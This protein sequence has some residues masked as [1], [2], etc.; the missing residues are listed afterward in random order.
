MVESN[1]SGR[2]TRTGMVCSRTEEAS[3]AAAEFVGKVDRSGDG[4]IDAGSLQHALVAGGL[5]VAGASGGSWRYVATTSAAVPKPGFPVARTRSCST[6]RPAAG[7]QK[8]PN[9]VVD[10]SPQDT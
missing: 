7:G 4:L 10:S 1:I 6:G 2:R 3:V 5:V 8:G 9:L